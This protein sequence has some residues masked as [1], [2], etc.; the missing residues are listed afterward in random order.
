MP[1]TGHDEPTAIDLHGA[2]PIDFLASKPEEVRE[3]LRQGD[4]VMAKWQAVVTGCAAVATLSFAIASWSDHGAMTTRL[5]TVWWPIGLACV[6]VGSYFR[7]RKLKS[8][9]S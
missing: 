6:S 3:D 7:Y 5:E 1:G 4:V 9:A 8:Q 2:K